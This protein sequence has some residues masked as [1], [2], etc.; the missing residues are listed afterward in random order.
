MNRPYASSVSRALTAACLLLT[1]CSGGETSRVGPDGGGGGAATDAGDAAGGASASGG[2]GGGG[3]GSGGTGGTSGA[4]GTAGTAGADGGG[5]AAGATDAGVDAPPA[6]ATPPDAGAAMPLF[7]TIHA[8]EVNFDITFANQAF[9]EAVNLGFTGVRTDIRWWQVEP[10]RDQPDATNLQFY[11]DYFDAAI[12]HGLEPMII[13]SSEPGWASDLRNQDAAAFWDEYEEYVRDIVGAFGAR[14]D[15]YQLWNEANHLIDPIP[16]SD[17]HLLFSR[18]GAVVRADDPTATTYVNVMANVVGWEAA[19]TDWVTQAGTFIDVIGVDH[20][21]GT[22]CCISWE[23]W[24]PFDTLV[25]RISNPSDAWF[26][27]RGAVIETGFSSWAAVVADEDDQ[28]DWIATSLPV[29]RQKVEAAEA[30]NPGSIALVGYYQLINADA[31]VQE[32]HFGIL[33]DDLSPKKGYSAL[34]TELAQF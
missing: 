32:G 21:P 18:A 30:A 3:G 22:W 17:D 12:A 33:H 2:V 20:Y 19:V 8:A 5:G 11:S 24:T 6:D 1:A 28:R 29:L 7:V 16:S 10:T 13:F 31:P 23:D 4:A 25:T 26:G 14:A 27:H 34:Q 9:Q 15:H